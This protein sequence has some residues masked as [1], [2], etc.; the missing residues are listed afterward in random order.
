MATATPP[1]VSSDGSTTLSERSEE[2]LRLS[3]SPYEFH[4]A[5]YHNDIT[6]VREM[7]ERGKDIVNIQD[8]FGTFKRIIIF[9]K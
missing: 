5:V 3:R 8:C 7:L 6:S 9:I 1:E 4:R 2:Y